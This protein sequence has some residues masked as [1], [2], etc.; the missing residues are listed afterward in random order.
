MKEVLKVMFITLL[1]IPLVACPQKEKKRGSIAAR[2]ARGQAELGRT[3]GNP[4]VPGVNTND[5]NR[6]YSPQGGRL[7]GAVYH[8]NQLDNQTFNYWTHEFVAATMPREEL[9]TVSGELNQSTGI[10]FWGYAEPNGAFNPS[11]TNQRLSI[12]PSNAE[13]RVVIWDSYAGQ[14]DSTG[15][16]ITE[17]P[18]HIRGQASGEI[19]GNKA[20]V[21]YQDSY[22]WVEL[23]GSFDTQYFSGWMMFDNANGGS[24]GPLGFFF[25]PTCSFFRCN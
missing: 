15:E 19:V 18:V 9:G 17:Y 12:S 6:A 23:N 4:G 22:G 10:R 14:V 11:N 8:G 2:Q 16:L 20:W 5:P 7:W 25:V 1:A 3:P 24:A 13:L 21:R